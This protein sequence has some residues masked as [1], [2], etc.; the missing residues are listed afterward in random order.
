MVRWN[1]SGK[2]S[3]ARQARTW[4]VNFTLLSSAVTTCGSHQ[5]RCSVNQQ[6]L[7]V[8][9][10]IGIDLVAH[11]PSLVHRRQ[12]SKLSFLRKGQ[13]KSKVGSLDANAH[14]M[15]EEKKVSV[16]RWKKRD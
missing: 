2:K 4:N 14:P 13:Q 6:E 1:Q 12:I 8:A 10:L 16:R 11:M 9:A 5:S 7:L 15:P 3:D